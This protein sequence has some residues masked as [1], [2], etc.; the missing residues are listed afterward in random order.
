[1]LDAYCMGT[2]S[3]QARTYDFYLPLDQERDRLD[4]HGLA[5]D[6]EPSFDSRRLVF[7]LFCLPGLRENTAVR[8]QPSIIQ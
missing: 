7:F 4:F 1:M 2:G 8:P 6:V 5:G 3:R